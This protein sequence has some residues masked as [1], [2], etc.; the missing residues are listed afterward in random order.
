[1]ERFSTRLT[2]VPSA[3]TADASKVGPWAFAEFR[4]TSFWALL[5]ALDAIGAFDSSTWIR[6]VD[7][8]TS[9]V[10]ASRDRFIPARRQRA[11]AAAIPGAIS[12]EVEGSHAAIVLGAD[13]F[14]PVLLDACASVTRRIAKR[15]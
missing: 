5:A 10:I 15:T 1:M 14:V 9:V 7:V 4:S 11:L 8:P 12:Y 3:L 6:R 13:E 2:E